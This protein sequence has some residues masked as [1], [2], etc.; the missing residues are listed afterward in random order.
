MKNLIIST[1]ATI[2]IAMAAPFRGA[3]AAQ[4]VFWFISNIIIITI[5]LHEIDVIMHRKKGKKKRAARTTLL[6]SAT[7]IA[8]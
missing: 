3:T 6:A 8:D 2:I 1:L 7:H 5:S 4:I